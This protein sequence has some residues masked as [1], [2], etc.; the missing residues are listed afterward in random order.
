VVFT[1]PDQVAVI[2]YQNKAVVYPPSF[3][4]RPKRYGRSPPTT[5]VLQ[6]DLDVRIT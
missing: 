3:G 6:V 1:V 4:Q 5:P 2:A